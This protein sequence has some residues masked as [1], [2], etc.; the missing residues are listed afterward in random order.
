MFRPS[1]QRPGSPSRKRKRA[2]ACRRKPA[3]LLQPDTATAAAARCRPQTWVR[4][5]EEPTSAPLGAPNAA[6]PVAPPLAR[7]EAPAGGPL[8]ARNGAQP[9]VLLWAPSG[10]QPVALL[11]AQNEALHAGLCGAPNAALPSA[12]NGALPGARPSA[13]RE[14]RP[15]VRPAARPPAHASAASETLPHEWSAPA[16]EA[17]DARPA[18]EARGAPRAVQLQARVS[19]AP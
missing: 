14:V 6:Q 7:S 19:T 17:T 3:H 1:G 5:P 8:G 2:L 4:R 16:P 18:R 9:V 11:W 12:L 13:P 10:A 15:V